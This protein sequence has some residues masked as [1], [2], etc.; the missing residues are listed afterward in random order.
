M[1]NFDAGRQML[2]LSKRQRRN[3]V[4]RRPCMHRVS[5]FQEGMSVADYFKCVHI[6]FGSLF[7][8]WISFIVCLHAL[9][10]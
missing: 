2:T 7:R 8:V 9:L 3:V 1:L 10:W 4:Q 6:V 5:P